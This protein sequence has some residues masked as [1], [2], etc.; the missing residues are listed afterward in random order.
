MQRCDIHP[1]GCVGAGGTQTQRPRLLHTDKLKDHFFL[2]SV[3]NSSLSSVPTSSRSLTLTAASLRPPSEEKIS[4][5][6]Q[7]VSSC[8][9]SHLRIM[10]ERS[11]PQETPAFIVPVLKGTE[12]PL[13]PNTDPG[14]GGRG[15]RRSLVFQC[16]TSVITDPF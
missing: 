6:L 2:I 12:R 1:T 3:E 5:D 16:T 11:E 14:S 9:R 15:Q 10:T 8:G 4:P 13:I 7:T